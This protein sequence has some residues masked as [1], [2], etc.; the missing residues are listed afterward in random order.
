MSEHSATLWS[1]LIHWID[2]GFPFMQTQHLVA[3]APLCFTLLIW[4]GPG[5]PAMW[6]AAV[7]M[8]LSSGLI[9]W[10]LFVVAK[11]R[12]RVDAM[13]RRSMWHRI[14]EGRGLPKIHRD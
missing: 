1:K 14:L 11:K 8:F 10:R 3:W 2:T 12:H 9:I 13:V 7:F 5:T 4:P 6:F